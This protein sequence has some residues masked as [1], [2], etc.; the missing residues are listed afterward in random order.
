MREEKSYKR[1]IVWQQGYQFILDVYK[2]T[3]NFPTHEKYGLT[4]Q[5]RRAAISTMANLVE[6]QA[7]R[8]PKDL[9]RYLDISKG[10]I[11]ECEFLLKLARDLEYIEEDVYSKLEEL[12]SKTAYLL[13]RLTLS[14]NKSV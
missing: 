1:L 6:G 10:S 4:S 9:L 14:F 2:A 3:N 13:H 7:K 12:R 5:L 8:T 11:W